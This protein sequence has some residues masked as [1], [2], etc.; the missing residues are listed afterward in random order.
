MKYT[1]LKMPRQHPQ[2]ISV[3]PI[4]L[5]PGKYQANN[6]KTFLKNA[7]IV[8]YFFRGIKD[9]W[10]ELCFGMLVLVVASMG[11]KRWKRD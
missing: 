8:K 4:N 11:T 7:A 3:V 9:F 2:L 5:L 1:E 10:V 6:I